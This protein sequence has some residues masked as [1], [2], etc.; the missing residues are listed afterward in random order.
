MRAFFGHLYGGAI[1]SFYEQFA[2]F[3]SNFLRWEICSGEKFA[4]EQFAQKVSKLLTKW[5]GCSKSEQ[6]AE[7]SSAVK[8]ISSSQRTRWKPLYNSSSSTISTR[9]VPVVESAVN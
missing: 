5:A 8:Q 2:H 7:E 3:V 6:I 4:R 9:V 1:C